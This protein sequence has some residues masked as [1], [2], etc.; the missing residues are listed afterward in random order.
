MLGFGGFV[1]FGDFGFIWCFWFGASGL[2][3]AFCVLVALHLA[4][5]ALFCAFANLRHFA[6]HTGKIQN[7]KAQKC[8]TSLSILSRLQ[9]F[10]FKS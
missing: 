2:A 6:N 10:G 9:I 3:T 1:A 5:L 8:A 7:P 4:K